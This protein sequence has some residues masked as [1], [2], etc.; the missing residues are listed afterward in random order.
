MISC[1][2]LSKEVSIDSPGLDREVLLALWNQPIQL[3]RLA[4]LLCESTCG[5]RVSFVINR[6]INFTNICVGSCSFCAFRKKD[7]YVLSEEEIL[8]KVEE[9]ETLGATEICLQGG[10]LP[11][12]VVEDYCLLLDVI[13]SHFSRIHLH[14]FSPMEVW[15]MARNSG[16][17]IRDAL[18][19]LKAS[20]LGSMPGTAAEILV[21]HVREAICPEKLGSM[22]WSYVISEAHLLGIPSTSTMLYGH[23]ESLEDRLDHLEVLRRI[24][25]RTGGFT[26][27]VLLPFIPGNNPLGI[28]S[29]ASDLLDHLKMHALSRVALHPLITNIQA[30]WVKLGREAAGACLEWGVNDLGGTLMEENISRSAGSLEGQ[31]LSPE[32]ICEI[33]EEHGRV[34]FERTTLYQPV[35]RPIPIW[36]EPHLREG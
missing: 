31:C 11:D 25:E 19:D 27:F 9:A 16:V 26:E 5:N 34:A 10:L 29:K 3:F 17:G 20:G 23:V 6:N 14:A 32:Q 13:R 36:R 8:Q 7:G 12:M 1:E 35:E 4:A 22:E 24:Q 18:L 15:H 30:S 28:R 2:S 33:I 21:D